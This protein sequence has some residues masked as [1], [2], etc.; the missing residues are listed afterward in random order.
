ML[1]KY[2]FRFIGKKNKHYN[3]REKLYIICENWKIQGLYKVKQKEINLI[4]VS[5]S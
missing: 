1:K 5:V 2:K 4:T 3:N